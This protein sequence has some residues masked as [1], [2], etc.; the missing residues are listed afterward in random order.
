LGTAAF[1]VPACAATGTASGGASP[2]EACALGCTEPLEDAFAGES[3]SLIGDR[4]IK[5]IDAAVKLTFADAAGAA[6]ATLSAVP[7]LL[8]EAPSSSLSP[9]VLQS[10]GKFR[11]GLP[12]PRMRGRLA[13]GAKAFAAR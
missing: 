2:E 7:S 5:D 8:P 1:L 9:S 10:A 4:G 3:T 12:K 6:L 13:A 11:M